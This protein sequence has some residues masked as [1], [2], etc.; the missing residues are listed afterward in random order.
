[1]NFMSEAVLK[2]SQGRKN[3]PRIPN[4]KHKKFSQ[5]YRNLNKK[6]L[7]LPK[8]AEKTILCSLRA[9]L[10]ASVLGNKRIKQKAN[11][12]PVYKPRRKINRETFKNYY[13][14]KIVKMMVKDL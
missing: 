10:T 5:Y 9:Q 3:R 8:T 2:P 7:E 4:F 13:K 6:P 14:T 12:E 11:H 1:M